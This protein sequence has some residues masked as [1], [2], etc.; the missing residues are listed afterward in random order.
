M[1]QAE[2]SS[3]RETI[4]PISI[5]LHHIGS[6]AVPGILAK[7][8]I[9]MLGEVQ[10]LEDADICTPSLEALGYEAMGS[11]GIDGRRYFRKIN[12]LGKRTH[13]LH[14]FEAKSKHAFRHLAFRDYLIAHPDVALAYSQLKETLTRGV[15]VSW[16]GYIEGKDPFV[17]R[18]EADAVDWYARQ[19]R[20]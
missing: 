14:V 20:K 13:H 3:I 15:G 2:A 16:E 12:A 11:Y 4:S 8:I 5:A 18:I 19:R 17:R 9:D 6:T 10:K 7:P 1:F